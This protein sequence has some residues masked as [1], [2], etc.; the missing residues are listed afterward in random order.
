MANCSVLFEFDP[1]V[2]TISLPPSPTSERQAPQEDADDFQGDFSMSD[3][4]N[5]IN[6]RI[7]PPPEI[8]PTPA[9]TTKRKGPLVDLFGEMEWEEGASVRQLVETEPEPDAVPH[10]T[11][12]KD[13]MGDVS[14]SDFCAPRTP[15]LQADQPSRPA[16]EKHV[17]FFLITPK[18]GPSHDSQLSPTPSSE[19]SS[20]PS[21]RTPSPPVPYLKTPQK[22]I[23][24]LSISCP[25]PNPA[26]AFT[27]VSDP[28]SISS[29]DSSGINSRE[30][31][32]DP[33]LLLPRDE[34][35]TSP[36]VSDVA[37]EADASRRISLD[38]DATM[39]M[40]FAESS[41]D[42][43]NGE[44]SFFAAMEDMDESETSII[45]P[46]LEN[47]MA[48]LKIDAT[49]RPE[50]SLAHSFDVGAGPNLYLETPRPGS[51]FARPLVNSA[52]KSK[53]FLESQQIYETPRGHNISGKATTPITAVRAPALPLHPRVGAAASKIPDHH[54]E[55]YSLVRDAVPVSPQDDAKDLPVGKSEHP[56]P[57]EM[58]EPAGKTMNK[59]RSLSHSTANSAA[60]SLLALQSAVGRLSAKSKTVAAAMA[61]REND[62]N[63]PATPT[64]PITPAMPS[65]AKPGAPVAAPS[66]GPPKAAGLRRTKAT[67]EDV[68]PPH[69][70]SM[71]PPPRP[72]KA[73]THATN[74][75][76]GTSAST[77]PRPPSASSMR[78][79]VSHSSL[80][81]LQAT[82]GRPQ[83]GAGSLS[84]PQSRTGLP[85]GRSAIGAGCASGSAAAGS[86]IGGGLKRPLTRSI[87]DN[88]SAGEPRSR[89][90]S[91]TPSVESTPSKGLSARTAATLAR[92]KSGSMMGQG[93]T[94]HSRTTS[95]TRLPGPSSVS[96]ASALPLL[97]RPTTIARAAE[98]PKKE[99]R[100]TSLSALRETLKQREGPL[101]SLK[102]A[103][104]SRVPTRET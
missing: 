9:P 3:F 63:A 59:R 23:P 98:A 16:T 19:S 32:S 7:Q 54:L 84:R 56:A 83:A 40:R 69:K 64:I 42:L 17:D 35:R 15:K 58:K 97:P 43:L 53:P 12:R 100:I 1:L 47:K 95:G 36:S 11:P 14:I 60:S 88:Q 76:A 99:G 2:L 21:I 20:S 75:T 52:S 78:Q 89:P 68:A 5:N 34:K 26:R 104:L 96:S 73:S 48:G 27:P 66:M 30:S 18:S 82:P 55:K 22:P 70:T 25:S 93:T 86:S 39:D 10:T 46:S 77:I 4:F 79:P 80:P 37:Q 72:L 41:F 38:L 94:G 29:P 65:A 81:N 44:S 24:A 90:P 102:S 45:I 92:V 31:P 91:T 49:P 62:E 71:L 101:G 67:I 57:A 6:S 87:S 33:S 8:D 28:K 61:N 13:L 50:R 103:G 74:A 51:T 85:S